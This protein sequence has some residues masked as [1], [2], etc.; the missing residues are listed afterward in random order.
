ML[1]HFMSEMIVLNSDNLIAS[2]STLD[3]MICFGSNAPV[4][5]TVKIF[6]LS[7]SESVNVA[8]FA[9]FHFACSV[10]IPNLA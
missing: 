2:C 8:T 10:P 7:L 3:N 9:E 6:S 5:S 1:S 4:V